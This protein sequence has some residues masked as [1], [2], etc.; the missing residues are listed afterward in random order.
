MQPAKKLQVYLITAVIS[1]MVIYTI[2][3]ITQA[4][5]Q[6]QGLT[7][8]ADS[9]YNT[10]FGLPGMKEDAGKNFISS[11]LVAIASQKN[12]RQIFNGII[13]NSAPA[14]DSFYLIWG[15]VYQKEISDTL[16]KIMIE[17]MTSHPPLDFKYA[18]DGQP[19]LFTYLFRNLQ[20]PTTFIETNDTMLFEG[21]PVSTV[22][23]SPAF[24][25]E[26]NGGVLFYLS[27]DKK[28]FALK[29]I[30]QEAGDEA[31]WI[32]STDSVEF[33]K[34][35]AYFQHATKNAMPDN[36]RIKIP[37]LDFFFQK[38]FKAN[39]IPGNLFSSDLKLIEQRYKLKTS[40]RKIKRSITQINIAAPKKTYEFN[41]PF[42]FYLEKTG[43][44]KPYFSLM[45]RNP[46][47][48]IKKR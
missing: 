3:Y 19:F 5:Y 10:V 24:G 48:L 44:A 40:A 35:E 43:D 6:E 17:K 14:P 18:T 32:S 2:Y 15:G 30:S 46:E 7:A 21:Q 33:A 13:S 28:V 39:E 20:L 22:F 47:I 29:V 16:D 36:E 38:D 26:P 11:S 9:L 25:K 37:R 31:V 34:A 4:P 42:S 41:K 45:V 1:F 27:D 12:N 23:Y 8:T